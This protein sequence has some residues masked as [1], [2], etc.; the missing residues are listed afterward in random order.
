MW[1]GVKQMKQIP[2]KELEL[3]SKTIIA[4]DN[5]CINR[6]ILTTKTIDNIIKYYWLDANVTGYGIIYPVLH[7]LTKEEATT[8][9]QELSNYSMQTNNQV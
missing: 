7:E 1:R 6:V 8:S 2:F 9:L 3:G 5:T 4:V